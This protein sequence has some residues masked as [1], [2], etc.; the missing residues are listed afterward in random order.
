MVHI[1]T[2][3]EKAYLRTQ[4]DKGYA[5]NST[6]VFTQDDIR[7]NLYNY[8]N[9]YISKQVSGYDIRVANGLIEDGGKTWLIYVNGDIVAK[10]TRREAAVKFAKEIISPK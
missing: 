7:L 4:I 3:S 1:L 2:S 9:P 5:R 8:E 6:Q 10:A